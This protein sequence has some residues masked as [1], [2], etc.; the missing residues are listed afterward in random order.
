[1]QS[2]S[3]PV[4]QTVLNWNF[5]SEQLLAIARRWPATQRVV[6]PDF[7]VPLEPFGGDVAHVI[8][9]VEQVGAQHFL[10]VCPVEAFDVRVLV[11]FAWMNRNSMSCSRHQS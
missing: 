10:P 11:G 4:K 3:F 1:G 6:R 2:I 9:R 8:E 5:R 7:V